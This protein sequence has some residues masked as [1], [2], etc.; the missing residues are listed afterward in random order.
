[1]PL[2]TLQEKQNLVKELVEV[3]ES[4]QQGMDSLPERYEA[5]ISQPTANHLVIKLQP[6]VDTSA[7][8]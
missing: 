1:M 7:E 8:R 5:F 4:F 2:L 6:I 3:V